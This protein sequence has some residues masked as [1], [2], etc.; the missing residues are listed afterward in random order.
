MVLQ[1]KSIGKVLSITI[2]LFACTAESRSLIGEIEVD[3]TLK[4][5]G[6]LSNGSTISL[7]LPDG[8]DFFSYQ[9]S[10]NI[11]QLQT[12]RALNFVEVWYDKPRR[13]FGE[14]AHMF[15]VSV[16]IIKTFPLE[17]RSEDSWIRSKQFTT[18]QLEWDCD[19]FGNQLEV[20]KGERWTCFS[21]INPDLTVV[22]NGQ[23]Y[24]W[25]EVSEERRTQWERALFGIVDSVRIN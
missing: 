19:L 13:I 8:G 9:E 12:V 14:Y 24:P 10:L 15:L 11:E 17:Y 1:L 7:V 2:F 16:K 4:I 20:G 5:E 3:K 25:I 23:M 6:H 22:V 21:E 18:E